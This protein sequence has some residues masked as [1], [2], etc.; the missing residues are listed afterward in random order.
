MT[1]ATIAKRTYPDNTALLDAAEEFF[2]ARERNASAEELRVIMK[3]VPISPEKALSFK[4]LYGKDF[5][6][7]EFNL[8]EADAALGA[9]WLDE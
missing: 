8:S 5:V 2:A 9:G 3:K 4:R 7:R 6:V 1:T